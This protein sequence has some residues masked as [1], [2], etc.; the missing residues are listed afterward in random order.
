MIY[1]IR[2]RYL[3]QNQTITDIAKDMRLSRPKQKIGNYA[4]YTLWYVIPTLPM[5]LVFPL[6][7]PKLEFWLTL[8]A[9]V[10]ITILFLRVFA[11]VLR[12]CRHEILAHKAI[13]RIWIAARNDA[14]FFA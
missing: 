2:R 1:E 5:F 9:C 4:W 6:V 13:Q 7:L 8:L 14:A 3:V 11:H 12:Q 10:I